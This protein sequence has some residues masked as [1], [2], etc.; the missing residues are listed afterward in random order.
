MTENR[1]VRSLPE[2]LLQRCAPRSN[3]L[4][5]SLR[6][7]GAPWLLRRLA[8]AGRLRSGWYERASPL[9]PWR[10]FAP[11]RPPATGGPIDYLE[12]RRAVRPGFFF[13]A[14]GFEQLQPALLALDR[15]YS[16]TVDAEAIIGG[17]FTYFDRHCFDRGD[18]PDWLSEPFESRE[19]RS[20]EH[21]SRISEAALG[22]PKLFWEIGRFAFAYPL[23]RAY[24]RTRDERYPARFWELFHSFRAACPPLAGVQW[25][26]GQ[27]TSFRLFAAL[28]ASQAFLD[29][30]VTT[31]HD[32]RAMADF[33]QVSGERIYSALPY[34]L[35]QHNNHGVSECAALVSIGLVYPE[36]SDSSAWLKAGTTQL[37]DQVGRLVGPD[38]QFS[39]HSTNYHRVLLDDLLWVC[40]LCERNNHPLP[41]VVAKRFAL[42]ADWL[43]QM[44]A[45]SHARAVFNVGRNDG[46]NVLPL[47]DSDYLDY[48]P[49]LLA[50][51]L[52]AKDQRW[53]DS[54]P[55]DEKSLWLLGSEALD[56]PV[57]VPQ[58]RVSLGGHQVIGSNNFRAY[59]RAEERW[60]YRPSEADQLH[61]SIAHR[62]SMI[63]HDAGTYSYET[64]A[65]GSSALAD[66]PFHNT[67]SVPADPI[68][69]PRS[70]FSY[71]PW[72]PV[73]VT[74]D[75]DQT[76]VAARLAMP[77]RSQRRA[78]RPLGDWGILV[79]DDIHL[80]DAQEIRLRW[81]L[82]YDADWSES[83]GSFVGGGLFLRTASSI[84]PIAT[85]LR[86][87]PEKSRR[88]DDPSTCRATGY[89]SL[90]PATRLHL[91]FVATRLRVATV[92][93]N[94]P[95]T[96]SL[97]EDAIA[98]SGSNTIS[99][100]LSIDVTQPL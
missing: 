87:A 52:G 5:E 11:D 47:S 83:D 40:R 97:D 25:M 99:T 26:C 95:F 37:G 13:S 48:R 85:Q 89:R 81:L 44:T 32:I 91:D 71:F 20:T 69:L 90:G 12:F 7:Q 98:I 15:Q 27:E 80:Q 100:I 77:N 14:E 33:V 30:E 68:M 76:L 6:H 66:E 31:E 58:S 10:P 46:A 2:R 8:H 17:S 60:D 36:L 49:T 21:W 70:K 24:A 45:D 79:I 41:Q 50:A 35:N 38:G 53:C 63:A 55:W 56:R 78:F 73:T 65:L 22:D 16:V 29:A 43:F 88:I 57:T 1:S 9:R 4:A 93:A 28:F 67:L 86:S 3:L 18:N 19:Q 23:V 51:G 34:A 74:T 84:P 61:I 92:F 59:M 82:D 75:A 96:I 42:A 39:Q 72:T 54:G 94:E 64:G 62:G